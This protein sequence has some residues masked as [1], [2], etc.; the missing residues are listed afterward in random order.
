MPAL[1]KVLLIGNLGS[2]PEIAA[3]RGNRPVAKISLA[4]NEPFKD[5]ATG[6]KQQ[7]TRWHRVVFFDKLA[8]IVNQYLH[9]G[10]LCYVEGRLNTRTW[11]T[12]SGERRY[13][14]EV[15]GDKMQMLDRA[16]SSGYQQGGYEEGAANQ[17]G[18]MGDDI[19]F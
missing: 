14:T 17:L 3:T 2:D 11:E 10:S 16:Q 12:E 15:I 6:E 5:K 19:P 8:E 9:K 18:D 7:R 1:N 4:T 13:M